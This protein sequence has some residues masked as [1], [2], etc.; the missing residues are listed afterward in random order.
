M[1]SLKSPQF[2]HQPPPHIVLLEIA[3][4]EHAVPCIK[5]LNPSAAV[6]LGYS[7]Q[8]LIGSP[9]DLM[10]ATGSDKEL[11]QSAI[12]DVMDKNT[13]QSFAYRDVE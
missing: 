3:H 1:N 12:A 8:E 9:A 11:W 10:Y 7:E 2:M 13:S 6:F 4:S 5:Q